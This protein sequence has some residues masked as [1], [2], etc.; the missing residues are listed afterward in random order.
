MPA[1]PA[2]H[3][4]LNIDAWMVTAGRFQEHFFDAGW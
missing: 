2:R 1:L 3:V 4:P